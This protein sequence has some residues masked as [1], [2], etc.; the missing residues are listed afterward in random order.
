MSCGHVYILSLRLPREIKLIELL[1]SVI[2]PLVLLSVNPPFPIPLSLNA[3]PTL[4]LIPL[5]V[6]DHASRVPLSKNKRVLGVLLGQDD[7][8]IINVANSSVQPTPHIIDKPN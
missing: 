6:V 4:Q 1:Y 8:N 7:G 3:H 5:Q 2:H